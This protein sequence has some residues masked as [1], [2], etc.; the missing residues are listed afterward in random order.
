MKTW[1]Q[2]MEKTLEQ[3][4]CEEE[5]EVGQCKG[6]VA[7]SRGVSFFLSFFFFFFVF[8][9]FLGPLSRPMEV[10]RLGV[11]SEL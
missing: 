9:P 6:I 10:P 7:W 1:R 3:F 5:Q 4:C 2:Y 11:S 8:L